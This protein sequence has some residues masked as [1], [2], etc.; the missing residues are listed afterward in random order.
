MRQRNFPLYLKIVITFFC[1]VSLVIETNA[2]VTDTAFIKTY[3]GINSEVFK[4]IV[5]VG[6][7]GFILAGY[8]NSYG[9]GSNSV[10]VVRVKKDGTHIWSKTV[11]GPGTDFA[12]SMSKDT[13][14][15]IFIAGTTNSYGAG[16]YDGYL[17]KMDTA[18][19]ISWEKTFGGVDWDFLN[20]VKVMPDQSILLA[21]ESYSFSGGGSDAWVLHLNTN[22]DTTWTRNYG[23]SG[24][25]AFKGI[26]LSA[27]AIYLTGYSDST[28]ASRKDG[29]LVKLDYDGNLIYQLQ[30]NNEGNDF[31]NGS[32]ILPNSNLLIYGSTT[33]IDSTQSDYW[34]EELDTNGVSQWVQNS[35]LPQNDYFNKI[36]SISN[37]RL[38]AVGQLDPSGFGRSSMFALVTNAFG[39]YYDSH[40]FGGTNDEEGSSVIRTVDGGLAFVG[41]TTSYGVANKDAMLVLL[42]SDTS[43]TPNL[44]YNNVT[45]FETL[46]PIGVMELNSQS[47]IS[48]FPNPALSSIYIQSKENKAIGRIE[49]TDL[50][51]KILI[52]SSDRNLGLKK[53]DVTTIT[54]TGVYL[55]KIFSSGEWLVRRIEIIR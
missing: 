34:I 54:E 29:L 40:S 38:L 48:V 1:F 21:G 47:D 6:D 46:S 7:S 13:S 31:L 14:G 23:N 36:I 41:F 17:I 9:N 49:L 25:D 15:N 39:F 11:G 2:M 51:G 32:L 19:T 18:G 3:G 30:K 44:V 20:S 27:T 35:Y 53:L 10:Y 37:N 16:G 43:V 52:E 4:D 5:Q 50:I 22:G 42:R 33:A 12:N 24:N 26:E 45:Y 55:L 8:T 28:D